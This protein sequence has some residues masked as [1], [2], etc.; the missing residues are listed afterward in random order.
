MIQRFADKFST[1]F[2]AVTTL[3]TGDKILLFVSGQVGMPPEGPPRVVASTFEEEARQCFRNVE[4][5]LVRAGASLKDLVRINA[6]LTSAADYPLYDAV[7]KE[8]LSAAPPAS[9]TVIVAGL[10]A[11]ARLEIDGIAAIAK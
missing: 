8:L 6:Y 1:S 2:S 10:L 11:N 3:D 7:R 5:A 4:S 9:A